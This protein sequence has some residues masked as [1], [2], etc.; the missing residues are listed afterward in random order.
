MFSL[1]NKNGKCHDQDDINYIK[2]KEAKRIFRKQ[3]RMCKQKLIDS[4]LQELLQAAE[5]DV[6]E[7]FKMAKRYKRNK[8]HVQQ[9]VYKNVTSENAEDICKLFGTYFKD[10]SVPSR[11]GNFDYA[12]ADEITS[13]IA[14]F[15]CHQYDSSK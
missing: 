3:H 1:K 12:F 13:I 9:L 2:Y 4:R 7:Y 10:L 8:G 5:L 11:E 6:H 15:E 14:T